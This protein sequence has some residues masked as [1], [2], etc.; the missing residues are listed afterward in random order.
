[1]LHIKN[2]TGNLGALWRFFQLLKIWRQLPSPRSCASPPIP[3][4]RNRGNC[5]AVVMVPCSVKEN[6]K[7]IKEYQSKCQPDL[8]LLEKKPFLFKCLLQR[9]G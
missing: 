2:Y 3:C 5:E 1:M 4:P 6:V 7:K 8:E 9:P